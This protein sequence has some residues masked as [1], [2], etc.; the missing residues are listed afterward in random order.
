[1][2]D[3]GGVD[4]LSGFNVQTIALEI[5]VTWLTTSSN[6]SVFGAYAST[7]RP[8]TTV[9]G[10]GKSNG[11]LVQAQRLANP[12]VN[13]VIIG[14]ADKDRWNATAPEQEGLFEQYYLK[15]RVSLALQLATTNMLA[16]SCLLPQVPGCAPATPT[17]AD[18]SLSA[19]NRTDLVALLLQYNGIL[20]GSGRGGAKSDLLR[21]DFSKGWQPPNMQ[22]RLGVIGGDLTGWPNG[23]RPA[24]DVTDIAVQA[25]GGQNYVPNP[26]I[27]PSGVGDGVSVN[28]K[29]LPSAFP[30][31]ATPHDGRNRVHAN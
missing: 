9:R 31:L 22:N 18:T 30:F 4:Q 5:P 11:K 8:Q 17:L 10:E 23:R 13:E 29:P 28:D 19:F 16:T 15:P 20:Y 24:D 6:L 3:V 26:S 7:S 2:T 25:A 1:L 12:L 21:L 27:V 14:V